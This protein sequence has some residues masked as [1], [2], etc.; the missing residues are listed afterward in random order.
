MFGPVM[1]DRLKNRVAEKLETEGLSKELVEKMPYSVMAV[2][3]LEVGSQIIDAVGIADFY[4]GKLSDPQMRTWEWHGYMTERFPK[5]FPA[6]KPF[7]AEYDKMFDKV[8]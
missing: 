8:A 2:E 3:D 1:L 6:R 4:D 5:H 7:D